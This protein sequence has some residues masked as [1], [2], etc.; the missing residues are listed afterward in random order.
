[1]SFSFISYF[2]I[3]LNLADMVIWNMAETEFWTVAD[4]FFLES[5]FFDVTLSDANDIQY[6]R[7]FNGLSN[8]FKDHKLNPY[9]VLI[10]S[11]HQNPGEIFEPQQPEID[12]ATGDIFVHFQ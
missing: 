4:T 12:R 8:S 6:L 2:S 3:T 5:R 9:P 11:H 7:S 1:M 10:I